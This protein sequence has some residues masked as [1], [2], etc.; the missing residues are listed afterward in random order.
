VHLRGGGGALAVRRHAAGGGGGGGSGRRQD[1]GAAKSGRAACDGAW[2]GVARPM[3]C[4]PRH[5]TRQQGQT[6]FES[7]QIQMVQFNLKV[8]KF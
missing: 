5:C 6:P 1:P 3:M 2:T 8:F 4:G 7:I